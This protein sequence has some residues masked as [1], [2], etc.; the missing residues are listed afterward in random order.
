[1]PK[2][3]KI[4]IRYEDLI[5]NTEKIFKETILFLSEI[6]KFQIDEQKIKFSVENSKF[7]K[8]SKMEDEEGFKE[9]LGNAQKFFRKGEINQYQ[10]ILTKGQIEIINKKFKNEMEYLKYL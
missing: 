4:L 1:M 9:N 10:N 6:L 3:P 5:S 8:L 7:E 2:I